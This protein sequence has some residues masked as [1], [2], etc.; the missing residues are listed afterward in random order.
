[1]IYDG[2]WHFVI[3]VHVSNEALCV[4]KKQKNIRQHNFKVI[5]CIV[6]PHFLSFFVYK[7]EMLS[8]KIT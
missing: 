6:N 4:T 7:L 8:S 3:K 5:R 2:E 1:M